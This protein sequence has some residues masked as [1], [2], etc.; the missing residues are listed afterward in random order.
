MHVVKPLCR[1]ES[2]GEG[3]TEER[4]SGYTVDLWDGCQTNTAS[5]FT[6]ASLGLLL[7][8]HR[9]VFKADIP[10][11]HYGPKRDILDCLK[12]DC[13]RYPSIGLGNINKEYIYNINI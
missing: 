1:R 10:L 5:L 9:F 11:R 8:M 13:M 6:P 3:L 4:E 2:R 12:W 7:W